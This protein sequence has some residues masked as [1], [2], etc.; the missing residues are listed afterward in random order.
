MVIKMNLGC[1]RLFIDLKWKSFLIENTTLSYST[2]YLHLEETL[3]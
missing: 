3:Y 2:N 1:V